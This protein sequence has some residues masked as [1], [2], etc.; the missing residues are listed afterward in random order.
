MSYDDDRQR[1]LDRKYKDDPRREPEADYRAPAEI[2]EDEIKIA[3]ENIKKQ[4]N[5]TAIGHLESALEAL[6]K[7]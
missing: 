7:L 2:A 1:E 5:F 6:K 3:I 4:R